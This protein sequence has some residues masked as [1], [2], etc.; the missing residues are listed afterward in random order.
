MLILSRKKGE[1]I[2]IGGQV[3]ITIVE[4]RGSTVRVGIEAPREMSVHRREVTN[5]INQRENEIRDRD[6]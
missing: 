5:A 6:Q 4:I 2:D 1:V 3:A